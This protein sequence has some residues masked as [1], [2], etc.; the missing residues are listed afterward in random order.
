MNISAENL[1]NKAMMGF[2]HCHIPQQATTGTCRGFAVFACPFPS[3]EN[4]SELP[5][6]PKILPGWSCKGS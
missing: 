3:P 4:P 6:S 1:K 2:F 5:G